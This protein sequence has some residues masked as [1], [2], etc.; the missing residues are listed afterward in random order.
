[1]LHFS[2]W[3]LSVIDTCCMKYSCFIWTACRDTLWSAGQ[4]LSGIVWPPLQTLSHT[5]GLWQALMRGRERSAGGRWRSADREARGLPLSAVKHQPG[6]THRQQITSYHFIK[7]RL[8]CVCHW[9]LKAVKS[10]KSTGLPSKQLP[11]GRVGV[12]TVPAAHNQQL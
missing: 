6:Q 8:S 10:P 3:R 1:M 5:R 2:Q 4:W 11:A 9:L 7:S 12:A